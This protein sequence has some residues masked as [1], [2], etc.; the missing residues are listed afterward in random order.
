MR[1]R[2]KFIFLFLY[3]IYHLSFV[4]LPLN[5]IAWLTDFTFFIFKQ[6]HD[7]EQVHRQGGEEAARGAEVFERRGGK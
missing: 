4:L 6:L 3:I 1:R 7:P 5:L 2:R